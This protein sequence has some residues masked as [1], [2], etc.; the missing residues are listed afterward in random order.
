MR[1]A[2]VSF[3][4]PTDDVGDHANALLTYLE[5]FRSVVADK[6]AGLDEDTLRSSVLPSGW[7][8]LELVKHLAFMERRWVVWGF[9]GEQIADPWGD[10]DTSGRWHVAPQESAASLVDALR[11]GGRRTREV[12]EA[13]PLSAPA[14]TG[15]RFGADQPTPTLER[16]LLH[17][18]Q[19]YARHVGHLDVVRELLDGAVGE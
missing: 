15:G 4:D 17:L 6:V 5:F 18:L 1:M 10:D 16:I 7:S 3:P 19:E 14:R 11:A 12:V 8:P 9:L 2:A 13:S